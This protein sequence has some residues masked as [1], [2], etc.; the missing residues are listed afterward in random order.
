MFG[1]DNNGVPMLNVHGSIGN[2]T[3]GELG[4]SYYGGVYN[5]FLQ[6]DLQIDKKRSLHLISADYSLS[7]NK[8]SVKGEY[9]I[10]SIDVR[11]E[12]S[13]LYTDKQNAGFMD[14][15][16]AGYKGKLLRFPKATLNA[17][18]R[19]ET[20]DLNVGEFTSTQTNIGDE[21]WRIGFGLGFRPVPGTIVRF[22]YFRGNHS[23]F[24][25]NEPVIFGGYQFGVASYF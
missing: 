4:L 10:A 12:L 23:D 5:D 15:T 22:N 9:A 11:H 17:S 21:G 1:E 18:V 13:P 19:L 16:L 14:C 20:S 3:Y 25:D 7:L 6:D 8:W 24:L 2:F